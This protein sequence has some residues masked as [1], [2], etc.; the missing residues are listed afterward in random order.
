MQD[1]GHALV[2]GRVRKSRL[3]ADITPELHTVEFDLVYGRVS[4]GSGGLKR[5]SGSGDAEHASAGCDQYVTDKPSAGMEDFH[6]GISGN[7]G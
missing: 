3:R 2:S 4:G 1:L 7:T 5:P 6:T